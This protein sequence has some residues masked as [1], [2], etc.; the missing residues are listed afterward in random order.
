MHHFTS[1]MKSVNTQECWDSLILIRQSLGGAGYSAWS[2]IPQ[3]IDNFSPSTTFEGDNTVMAQQSYNYLSKL[4]G[5]V[6]KKGEKATG[7]FSYLNDLDKLVSLKCSATDYKHFLNI[8][9]VEEAIKVNVAVM[10]KQVMK[11]REESKVSKKDFINSHCSTEIVSVSNAHIKLV[12]FLF[13]KEGLSSLNCSVNKHNLTNLCM[14]YG[15]CQLL[16]DSTACYECFYFNQSSK[17]FILNAIKH[18]NKE[19]RPS[20]I[21]IIET[22]NIPDVAL[23]SAIGNSY[24]DIY[25]QHLEWA[26]G[27]K[28]N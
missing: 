18:I 22:V 5:K 25:E 6:I 4:A 13:F 2:G 23:C 21:N 17:Q 27:S 16:S 19:L 28:L 8:E 1:G 11:M 9:N 15:L 12:N 24:G 20:I 26:K 3:L 14:L 10:L 7:V